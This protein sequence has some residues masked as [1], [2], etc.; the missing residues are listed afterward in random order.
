MYYD[1]FIYY[2]NWILQIPDLSPF[3][4]PYADNVFWFS[5]TVPPIFSER[6]TWLPFVILDNTGQT[7]PHF[8]ITNTIRKQWANSIAQSPRIFNRM[9]PFQRFCD[10][11]F[12]TKRFVEK[13]NNNNKLCLHRF[14]LR[15]WYC[16]AYYSW[17]G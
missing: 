1:C 3:D 16:A 12:N 9:E 14:L 4:N 15:Q 11:S 5:S 17:H 10:D 8:L 13:K 7:C 2:W 6:C